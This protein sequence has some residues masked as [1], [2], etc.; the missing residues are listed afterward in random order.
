MFF[1]LKGNEAA[2]IKGATATI[3]PVIITALPAEATSDIIDAL[4]AL[5]YRLVDKVGGDYVY[6]KGEPI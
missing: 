6:M 5:D 2:A 4:Q 3:A 1:D